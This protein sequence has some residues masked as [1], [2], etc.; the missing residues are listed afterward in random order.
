MKK[1]LLIMSL[2]SILQQPAMAQEHSEGIDREAFGSSLVGL[3]VGGILGGPP[4][5][6]LGFAG[7][8][9]IGDLESQNQQ[10]KKSISTENPSQ[11]LIEAQAQD[12]LAQFQQ[13]RKTLNSEI[14]ALQ[15]GFSFCLGFRSG[16]SE[17]EPK[18]VT[19]LDSLA[20]MLKA[21]PKFQLQIE[22][23][24]D[25]RGSEAF[26]QDLS[27]KRAE[28]VAN[29]LMAAGLAEDRITTRYQ[30]ESLAIYP[31]HDLEGLAFDRMVQITLLQGEES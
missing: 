19:Q 8:A 16:S 1:Q 2:A 11:A 28:A 3:V 7:G 31:L 21:F 9:T 26:N 12:H 29:L 4:G 27:R 15:Q 20:Q 30:G 18:M 6:V 24:A 23:G 25:Q 10:L 22:A 14:Q 5:A 17:I 13:Q